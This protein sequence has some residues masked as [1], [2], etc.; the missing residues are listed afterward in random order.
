MSSCELT[1]II[2]YPIKSLRGISLSACYAGI[3]GL[4]YDRRW[5]LVNKSGQFFSQRTLP[6]L[7]TFNVSM[8]EEG[9]SVAL[10]NDRI[11][12]PFHLKSN[13]TIRVRIW[14]SELLAPKAPAQYSEWFSDHLK[15]ACSLVFMN[16]RVNRTLPEKYQEN[17]EMVSFADAF[18]YLL[19]GESSLDDLNQRLAFRLP[20][21][22]FRPNLVFSGGPAYH[23]DTLDVFEI[24]SARFKRVKS[25]SRCIIVNTDQLTGE[26]GKEPLRTLAGYRGK[27]QKAYF[28]QNLI[29]LK[30]GVI[31][32]GDTLIDT[33]QM[34]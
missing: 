11:L 10:K 33:L 16:G 17:N 8:K 4:Q 15:H 22:R 6:E 1:D 7:A 32:R 34:S 24:G 12:I 14:E 9:F 20:M 23:E 3:K 18:P 26:R 21:N 30:E 19:I 29:C 2:I 13:D 28:G 5:M 27:E 25:C 31:K